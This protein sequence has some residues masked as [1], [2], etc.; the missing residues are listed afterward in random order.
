[1][2]IW[3]PHGV[4]QFVGAAL[5][6]RQRR[7][8]H[9]AKRGSLLRMAA[10]ERLVEV[11]PGRLGV[12]TLGGARAQDRLSGDPV[13]R[14]ALQLLVRPRLELRDGRQRANL[15]LHLDLLLLRHG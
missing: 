14:L 6:E 2:N 9:L 7:L 11:R 3:R 13:P 10:R 12:V 1:M 5:G 8:H 15:H 4:A